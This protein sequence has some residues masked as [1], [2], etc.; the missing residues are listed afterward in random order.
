MEL[1]HHLHV[2]RSERERLK[3]I[4]EKLRLIHEEGADVQVHNIGCYIQIVIH[5]GPG[6]HIMD[7]IV[8]TYVHVLIL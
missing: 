1:F 2:S 4:D 6:F 3:A 7:T 5:V 8:Y